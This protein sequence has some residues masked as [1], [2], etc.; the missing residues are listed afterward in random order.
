[1]LQLGLIETVLKLG[2]EVTLLES[3]IVRLK[4]KLCYVPKILKLFLV[5]CLIVFGVSMLHSGNPFSTS[6]THMLHE[7]F[8][9][10]A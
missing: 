4:Q 2:G 7:V 6:R 3:G 5:L 9:R 10:L 1:M 8:Q